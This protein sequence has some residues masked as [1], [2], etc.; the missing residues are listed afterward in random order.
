ML[1][2]FEKMST[3][4]SDVRYNFFENA[5]QNLQTKFTNNFSLFQK[6][7]KT[8]ESELIKYPLLACNSIDF[9]PNKHKCSST[10]IKEYFE[11]LPNVDYNGNLKSKNL[12]PVDLVDDSSAL[13]RCILS[14]IDCSRQQDLIELK[15]RCLV[16]AVRHHREYINDCEH[17]EDASNDPDQ[18]CTK[19]WSPFIHDKAHVNKK[20]NFFSSIETMNFLFFLL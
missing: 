16:D 3:T 17:F 14:L 18:T 7:C 2:H 19:N 9:D 15:V 11:L 12:V 8:I 1:F 13:F 5:L 10:T 6:E 4:E 20:K